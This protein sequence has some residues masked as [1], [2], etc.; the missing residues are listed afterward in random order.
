[1]PVHTL[2]TPRT[3]QTSATHTYTPHTPRID[4]PHTPHTPS[5]PSSP[6]GSSP[7]HNNNN[8]EH[9]RQHKLDEEYCL[10][11][12]SA[13]EI[14]YQRLHQLQEEQKRTWDAGDKGKAKKLSEE[15]KELRE[16]AENLMSVAASNIFKYKNNRQPPQYID[17]HGLH[18]DEALN[19]LKLRI[20]V[21][22]EQNTPILIV[23]Y[24]AGHHSVN[25]KQ[26]LKPV[27]MDYLTKQT[28]LSLR[29][30]YDEIM[31]HSNPGCVSV[32]LNYHG[33][34]RSS[35]ISAGSGASL[36][37]RSPVSTNT[38]G[39]NPS[40]VTL[41][42]T[43]IPKISGTTSSVSPVAPKENSGMSCCIIM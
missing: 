1:M 5:D 2:H 21:I 7:F 24:G 34:G 38:I 17:L 29:E 36:D 39:S 18:V 16:E 35:T 12:R 22:R 15:A 26:L 31:N 28:D 27:V 11:Q 13:A 42:R 43:L 10:S 33:T 4:V 19:F 30:D 41:E 9:E 32:K 3:P 25:H 6:H 14:V 23:I 37:L 8:E 40:T 20:Q